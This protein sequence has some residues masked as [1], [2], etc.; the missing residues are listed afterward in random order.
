M[1]DVAREERSLGGVNTSYRSRQPVAQHL[2]VKFRNYCDISSLTTMVYTR[3]FGIDATVLL[4]IA[5]MQ[6]ENF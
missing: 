5:A 3:K 1:S 4:L 2:G 6:L